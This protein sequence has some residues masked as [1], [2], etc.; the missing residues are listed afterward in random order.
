MNALAKFEAEP[1]IGVPLEWLQL[2]KAHALEQTRIALISRELNDMV[3]S[4][5]LDIDED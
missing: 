5:C 3:E 1:C 4:S 2:I